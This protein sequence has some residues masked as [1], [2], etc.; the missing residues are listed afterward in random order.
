[1]I[2]WKI[3][4]YI[5]LINPAF[6]KLAKKASHL[7]L[8]LDSIRDANNY[9]ETR[10]NGSSVALRS[11]NAR[12]TEQGGR[13]SRDNGETDGERRQA[14]QRADK[15]DWKEF[16]KVIPRGGRCAARTAAC[17]T[18]FNNA[19]SREQA[20]TAA[21]VMISPFSYGDPPLCMSLRPRRN[22]PACWSRLLTR[23][24]R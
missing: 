17:N 23:D 21:F 18:L 16:S 8:S 20:L 1:M 12:K 2:N 24:R 7:S 4:H 22:V 15:N 14:K 11:R 9:S 19:L 3:N 6:C 5:L 10:T 13:F